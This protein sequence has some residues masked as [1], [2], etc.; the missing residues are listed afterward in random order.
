MSDV[1]FLR[2]QVKQLVSTA[3]EKELEMMYLFFD[4]SKHNDWWDEINSEQKKT[5]EKGLAQLNRGEGISHKDVMKKTGKWLK[6]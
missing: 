1:S 2:S 5:I 3:S 4:A 6:K